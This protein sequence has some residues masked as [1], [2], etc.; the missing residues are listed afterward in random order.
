M[1]GKT[2]NNIARILRA[3]WSLLVATARVPGC[4]VGIADTRSA[5]VCAPA[6]SEG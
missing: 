6:L 5:G 3:T 1:A 2:L 4:R